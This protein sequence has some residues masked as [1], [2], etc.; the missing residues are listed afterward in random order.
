MTKV[1]DPVR[2]TGAQLKVIAA[3]L[4]PLGIF[5]VHAL[6]FGRWIVDDAG[7]SFAYARNLAA[8]HGLVAQPGLPPVEGYS[9]FLF[10]LLIAAF[11]A[12]GAFDLVWTPKALAF[13]LTAS[14]FAVLHRALRQLPEWPSSATTWTLTLLALQTSFVAWSVSGLETPLYVFL[15]CLLLHR[16]IA[17]TTR[18]VPRLIDVAWM[19]L[20][21]TGIAM[22]RPDGIVY[23]APTAGVLGAGFVWPRGVPRSTWRRLL[24]SYLASFTAA[25]G[26]FLV[27]RWWYFHDIL[28]NTYYAKGGQ[29]VANFVALITGDPRMIGKFVTLMGAVGSVLKGPVLA[30]VAGG[31]LALLFRRKLSLGH[32]VVG[33]FLAVAILTYIV[34]PLDWMRE[35]RFA[36]PFFVFFYPYGVALARAFC[37]ALTSSPKARSIALALA[38]TLA[39]LGTLAIGANRSWKFIARPAYPLAYVLETQTALFNRFCDLLGNPSVSVLAPDAGGNLLEGRFRL[40][41]LGMLTD[42]TIA[43]TIG[44]QQAV[45][46]RYVFEETKPTFVS[47]GAYYGWLARLDA[48]ERFRRDYVPIRE[49]LDDWA[50]REYRMRLHSGLY[51]RKDA[52]QDRPELLRAIQTEL[53]SCMTARQGWCG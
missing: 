18:P 4:I 52:V 22:T 36:T 1:P 20:L 16:A 5:G 11:Y 34:L 40:Y 33:A 24:A 50:Y 41:D 2:A 42:R 46:Y 45:F 48:D 37:T 53:N 23:L 30:L 26:A 31:T 25:Y 9:N 21:T 49:Y 15:L 27:F 29:E 14:S 10:V 39:V 17:I 35:Y 8:G 3:I 43:K 12:V 44:K 13:A 28:P 32:G 7:I 19:G 51:V 6:A 47:I 38:T